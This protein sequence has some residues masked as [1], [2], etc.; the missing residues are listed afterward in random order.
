MKRLAPHASP[1]DKR[2]VMALLALVTAIDFF[3]NGLF[4]F[5][6]SHIQGG[7]DA[8]P[9][10]FVQVIVAFACASMLVILNQAWLAHR[11]GYRGLLTLALSLFAAGALFSGFSDNTTE[12]V[13]AR[14]I[15]GAGSGALFTSSRILINLMFKPAQRPQA[16]RFFMIGIFGTSV[17]APLLAGYWIDDWGWRWV[18]WGVVPPAILAAI[19]SWFWL[20]AVAPKQRHGGYVSPM[21]LLLFI[22]G[23]VC[24]QMGFSE[25]RFNIFE[26]PFRVFAM[27]GLGIGLIFAFARHQWQHPTPLLVLRGLGHPAY[28]TGLVLYFLHYFLSNFSNYLFPQYVEIGQRIPVAQTGALMSLSALVSFIVIIWYLLWGVRRVPKKWLMVVAMAALAGYS[29]WFANLPASVAQSALWPGLLG[30]GIFGVLLV[31]P[32]AG[33][34]FRSLREE[35]FAHGYRNKNLLRQM[36]GSFAQAVAA[37]LLHNRQAIAHDRLIE[38]VNPY[39]FNYNET[40]SVLQ[41]I[42]QHQGIPPA[43]VHTATL[44]QLNEMVM[45]QTQVLACADLYRFLA[46]MAVF[47][48]V[49]IL[50]QRHLK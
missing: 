35:D 44:V 28:L 12:L 5:S 29:L 27:L 15:Q 31:I 4:V 2:W 23:V 11:L 3:E 25:A 6:A 18:F 10:E 49:V 24:V 36:A 34:T 19:G 40:A 42:L 38:S 9:Q 43:Q 16:T 8:G 33:L 26:H 41:G 45:Q 13:I 46:A 20:P 47:A 17:L 14:T 1:T 7:I 50:T 37:I 21:P 48:T 32:V 39:N 22:I 30:K